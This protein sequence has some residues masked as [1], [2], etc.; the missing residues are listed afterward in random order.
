[1]ADAMTLTPL[2]DAVLLVADARSTTRGAIEQARQQLDQVNARVIGTV[3][4]NFDPS[5]AAYT[6]QHY[7]YESYRVEDPVSRPKSRVMSWGGRRG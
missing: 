1:V 4:N 7:G 2:V 5:K 3:L 6:H